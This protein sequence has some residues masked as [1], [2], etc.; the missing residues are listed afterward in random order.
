MK[1]PINQPTNQSTKQTNNTNK[2]N[3][4]LI[5]SIIYLFIRVFPFNSGY[6]GLPL[7][8]YTQFTKGKKS[9]DPHHFGDIKW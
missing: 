6:F 4:Q 2:T 7:K 1:Q 3:K 5:E 9:S 8:T